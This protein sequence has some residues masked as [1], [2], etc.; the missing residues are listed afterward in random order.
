MGPTSEQKAVIQK[1]GNVSDRLVVM[2]HK[3]E[4]I[5]KKVY[6]IPAEKIVLIHHGIP[7]LPFVDSNL[8]KKKLGVEGRKVILTFGLLSPPKGI[9]HMIGA[10]PEIIK[11]HPETTYIILGAT[12]PSVKRE[13]GEA[14]RISL[15]R[16]ARELGVTKHIIFHDR[17]VNIKELGEF[18]RVADIYVTPYLAREQ[19]SSG[20]LAYALGAGKAI[21]STPYWYAE[22]MLAAGRGRLVPFKDSGA[23]ASEVI[24]LMDT[25]VECYAMRKRAYNFSRNMIW[26][27]VARSYL[28]VFSEVKNEL[29]QRPRVVLRTKTLPKV[30]SEMPPLELDHLKRITDDV[31]ILQHSTFIIPNRAHGYCTDDNTRA[32]I[33]ALM[34]HDFIINSTESFDLAC[35]YL[36]FLQHAFDETKGRFRNFM[37]YDRTWLDEDASFDSHARAIWGLGMTVALSKQDSLSHVAVNL[38]KQ[39]LPIMTEFSDPRSIAFGLVGIH[40]YLRRFGGDVNAK[41]I[42]EK[43]AQSLFKIYQSHATNDWPWIEDV[44]TYANGKIPQALLLSGRWLHQDEMI[45]AGLRSLEWL[46]KIQTDP[47]GYFVPIGNHGWLSRDGHRARFDQ[48]PIEAANMVEACIEAY[49]VTGN[50]KWIVEAQRCLDWFLGQQME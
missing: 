2:S 50:K 16:Q 8:Y 1:I 15:Q 46:V 33:V 5:L 27:E 23:L 22:E 35:V 28:N 21:I 14:Y 18:L 20:T 31:G 10:L 13:Q 12:H 48:Q 30:L 6:K 47:K 34:A 37:N 43:M 19:V 25:E 7:D 40:A 24:D 41:R 4:E 38:F 11:K 26:K 29:E 36:S 42:R 3:A 44:V 17:F 9:E 39:A 49:K 32:L 45:E